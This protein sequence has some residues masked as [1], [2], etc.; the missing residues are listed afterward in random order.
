VRRGH[1]AYEKGQAAAMTAYDEGQAALMA[2]LTKAYSEGQGAALTAYRD[3][4]NAYEASLRQ[5]SQELQAAVAAVNR[6][7][8]EAKRQLSSVL[9]V[10]SELKPALPMLQRAALVSHLLL[11]PPYRAGRFVYRLLTRA[12]ASDHG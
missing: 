2:A 7:L 11:G 8:L 3:G 5:S 4:Q 1:A 9:E 6:E 12:H 10:V